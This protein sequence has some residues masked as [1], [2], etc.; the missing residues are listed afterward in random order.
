MQALILAAGLGTRLRPL[1]DDR[2]KA[3]VEI[4]GK[5]LLQINVQRLADAGAQIMTRTTLKEV[6]DAG[7]LVQDAEDSEKTIPADLVVLAMGVRSDQ[8]LR[9]ELEAEFDRVVLVGD[10]QHPGQIREAL[11]AALDKALVY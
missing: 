3:L 5:T 6:T 1:T 8:S 10:A 11:H 7:I 9:A 4:N 2:P